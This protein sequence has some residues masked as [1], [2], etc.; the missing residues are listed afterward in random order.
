MMYCPNCKS[1]FRDGFKLCSTCNC[2]L[3]EVL[4]DE[5]TKD[6]QIGLLNED[7]VF[8]TNVRSEFEADIVESILSLNSIKSLRK[9][10]DADGYLSLYMSYSIQGVDIYVL[11]SQYEIAME[12]I[13]TEQDDCGEEDF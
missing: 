1:E 10:R 11:E 5:E 8:L 13:K 6:I 3:V 4:P 12:L 9:H 2:A 7:E